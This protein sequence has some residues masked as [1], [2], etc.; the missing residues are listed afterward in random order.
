[1]QDPTKA[2][3]TVFTSASV[4][5]G[6]A[7]GSWFS[8]AE[9]VLSGIAALIGIAAGIIAI[10]VGIKNLRLKQLQ[11]DKEKNDANGQR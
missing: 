6:G 7:L 5:V 8:K 9:P 2:V 1:M 4:S 3:H 11:L 10:W